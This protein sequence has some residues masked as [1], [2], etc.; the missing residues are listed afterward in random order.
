MKHAFDVLVYARADGGFL[1][2][3]PALEGC[4]AEGATKAELLS[5]TADAIRLRLSHPDPDM[6]RIKFVKVTRVRANVPV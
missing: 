2:K 1:A 4:T 5:A 3:V 6:R